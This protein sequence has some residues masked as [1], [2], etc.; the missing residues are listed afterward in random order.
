MELKT[1]TEAAEWLLRLE[2][3]AS[4]RCQREFV[5]WLKHSPRHMEEFL[6]VW[7]T[8][9]ATREIDTDRTIDV[10]ALLKEGMENVTP[11]PTA[12]AARP[13]PAAHGKRW[14]RWWSAGVAATLLGAV[15]LG[16]LHEFRV[17][18]YSTALGEQRSF[19]MEDGSLLHLNTQSRVTVRYS[20]H[21]REVQLLQGEALF[22]VAPD[23]SRPFRVTAGSTMIQA[24]GT[25]FNVYRQSHETTVS[26]L[27]GKVKVVS[28]ASAP[29]LPRQ[30]L[31]QPSA[32]NPRQGAAATL[33][34]GEQISVTDEGR[35]VMPAAADIDVAVAWRQRRLVFRSQRLDEIAAQ[36]NRY[37]QTV[38]RVEGMAAQKRMSG[39]F[40]ANQ[41]EAFLGFLAQD[42]QLEVERSAKESVIRAR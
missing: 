19:Q 30:P 26:V 8:A 15:V 32:A 39:T 18:A 36:F 35:S 1:A 9:G 21:A 38:I 27:E 6:L 42:P 10:D 40:N 25:Q 20:K 16:L 33:I 34:A 41:P 31:D 24:V 7:A 22:V 3:D 17:P 11:L 29:S 13:A 37:N 23:R 2:E 5:E 12:V 14:A 4:T 28:N